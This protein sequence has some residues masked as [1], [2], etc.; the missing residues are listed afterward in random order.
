MK[1]SPIKQFGQ[2]FLIEDSIADAI[3]EAAQITEDDQV[4]EIGPG[5]GI[6]TER[7]IKKTGNLTAFEIDNRLTV[8]LLNRF[9]GIILINRDVL[10]VDW[11]EYFDKQYSN[12]KIKLLSNLPYQITSPVLYKLEEFA[13]NFSCITLMLQKEVADRLSA[14]P[15]KK[16]YGVL[17]LRMQYSF[18]IKQLFNVSP[19]AFLPQPQVQSAV[20]QL[21]PR[22][23]KPVVNSLDT[24]RQIVNKAFLSR[25]KTLKNN[26]RSF[27]PNETV[28]SLALQSN[29]D[30]NRRG[31][32]LEEKDFINLADCL[33]SI[34]NKNRGK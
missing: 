29:I 5:K 16:A 20:I 1:I 13:E 15:G 19:S 14:V 8:Y 26:L 23:D 11:K 2:H 30:F 33:D 24:F 10:Q 34:N 21:L 28:N 18:K 9:P 31:E 12:K 32:T 17:T 25:R 22:K 7:I 3:I 4:W 6:L 27:L